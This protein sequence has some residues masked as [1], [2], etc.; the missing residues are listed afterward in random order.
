LDDLDVRQKKA[1]IHYELGRLRA[2]TL[3]NARGFMNTLEMLLLLVWRHVA[4]YT[5]ERGI[6]EGAELRSSLL[7][8]TRIVTTDTQRVSFRAEVAARLRPILSKLTALEIVSLNVFSIYNNTN[9]YPNRNLIYLVISG[10]RT[11]RI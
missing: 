8:S 5:S 1:L 11:Q 7:R 9:K 10:V 6:D 3:H 2:K 4:Y